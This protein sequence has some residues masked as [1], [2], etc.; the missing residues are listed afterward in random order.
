M[1]VK[2]LSSRFWIRLLDILGQLLSQALV[3]DCATA[4][5]FVLID[6]Q[7][8]DGTLAQLGVDLDDRPEQ[9]YTEGA[10]QL[11]AN[12]AVCAVPLIQQGDK[13]PISEFWV[14]F[15]ADLTDDGHHI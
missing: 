6:G 7:A 3:L 1:S 4:G 10:I 15:S 12:I 5:R 14:V 2:S 9:A 11:I 8:Q 13:N